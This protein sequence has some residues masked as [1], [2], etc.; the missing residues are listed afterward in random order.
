MSLNVEQILGRFPKLSALI[1]GDVC[2]DRWCRYDPGEAEPSRETGIPRIGVVSYISTPGAAGTVA[3]NMIALGIG[4]V[5]IMGVI[6][7]DGYSYELLNVMRA[8]RIETDLIARRPT[9]QTFTYT[10]LINSRTGIE[11]LPRV[12]A[13]NNRPIPSDV[14][15]ELIPLLEKHA[16]EFDIIL[17]S[18]Q[19]ETENGGTVSA[20]M[21]A[22]VGEIA[23]R[24]RD[25]VIWVDSRKR[26]EHFRHVTL[27]PNEDEAEEAC[28]RIGKPGDLA[29]LYAHAEAKHLIVTRGPLGSV[30]L[31]GN[32]VRT[33]KTRSV[34]K[35]VDICGAGDSF[36]AGGSATL[37]V[38]GDPVAAA[39]FGN[40]VASITIMQ[41]GTGTATPAQ[42]LEAAK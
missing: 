33:A 34:E 37:A 27:K 32:S 23:D 24:D 16:R 22:A 36:S 11:D 21:R 5:S 6:G 1:V 8:G 10:K 2:L 26:I 25:R 29:A 18:D 20:R 3:N 14:D 42:V 7:E 13:I 38:T 17:V 9:I 39:E 40:L 35:P 41:K 12:D 28:R 15:D 19:A 31:D 4:R 30:V